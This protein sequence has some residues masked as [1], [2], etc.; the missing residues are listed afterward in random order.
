MLKIG[1][2]YRDDGVWVTYTTD[3]GSAELLIAR[4]GNDDF[5]RAQEQLE[6]P[7]RKKIARDALSAVTRREISIRAV[8]E[9]ILL[10]WRGIAYG[11]DNEQP[12]SPEIGYSALLDDPDMLE[13]VIETSINN[14]NYLLQR[15]DAIS[16]KST[17]PSN[18]KG[19]TGKG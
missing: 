11:D 19:N 16:K 12:Y 13:F 18:G 17:K 5:L 6:R 8:A 1:K 15:E 7:Y 4:A 9:A 2:K 10:D 14:D 3:D